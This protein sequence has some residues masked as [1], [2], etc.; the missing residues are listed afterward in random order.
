M[1]QHVPTQQP[2]GVQ[3]PGMMQQL[4]GMQQL[5]M[6][7][8]PSMMAPGMQYMNQVTAGRPPPSQM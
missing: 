4:M 5:G 2:M 8:N 1:A 6:Q 3:Q 7:M